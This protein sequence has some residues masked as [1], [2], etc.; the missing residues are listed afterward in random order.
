MLPLITE[1]VFFMANCNS[2]VVIEEPTPK[3]YMFYA[4]IVINKI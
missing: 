2:K 3:I 1:F 4:L